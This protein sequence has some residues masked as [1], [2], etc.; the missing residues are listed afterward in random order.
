M[1]AKLSIKAKLLLVIFIVAVVSSALIVKIS[2]DQ[3]AHKQVIQNVD[4]LVDLS[5]V[6]SALVHE[7]QKERGA[8]AGYLGSK[9]KKFAQKLPQQ[10]N[11]TDTR[12]KEFN[13]FISDFDFSQYPG[14]LQNNING[15]KSQ[16]GE[17]SS[18]RSGVTALSIPLGKT[19]KYYTSLNA[20]ILD[21]VPLAGKISD[22]E[23]LAKILVSYSNFLYS[24]ERAGIERAVLSNTFA[25]KEFGPGM[26]EKAVTLIAEQNAYMHSFLSVADDEIKEYYQS[27]MNDASVKEVLQLRAKAFGGDFS[28]DSVYWFDTITKKIN[29]LKNIDDH[30]SQKAQ[31]KVHELIEKANETMLF[32]IASSLTFTLLI[33]L[34]I[35]LVSRSIAN[36]V[37]NANSQIQYITNSRDLSKD[38][39]CYSGGELA[40][41]SFAVNALIEAFRKM[42]SETKNSSGETTQSS[43]ELE[44]TAAHLS[45][46]IAKQQE[47]VNNINLLVKDVS[48][49]LDTTEEMAITTTE[50][51]ETTQLVLDEFVNNLGG[52]VE[53][54]IT[55]SS[56]QEE[57]SHKMAELTNQ[58]AE[59]KNVLSII[60]DI[61]DQ[62]NLLAL[63][64]A[65]EAARAGE[66]GRGFAVVADEVRKLAERTQ[67]SLS[68]IDV[69]TNIITQSIGDVSNEIN[70]IS[71][72][73]LEISESAGLLIEHASDSRNKLD[74]TLTASSEAVK[75]TTY[76]ATKTKELMMHME[77]V[78]DLS[79]DNK[80]AG[81]DVD[82][83]AS[84]LYDKAEHLNTFLDKYT[85]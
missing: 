56:K 38:V 24:K 83:V 41:I 45:A 68:E 75:K 6:L 33:I 32:T 11:L 74:A 84:E 20:K 9:G 39:S 7:T 59:I 37:N 63:N 18:I 34:I 10:R 2:Y 66:H 29:I 42:I 14:E 71:K 61:A 25:L 36:G 16:L 85:I 5:G 49:E 64:A 44:R 47:S 77:N 8:S 58:A 67:K 1:L 76:I 54:I 3:N 73:T 48:A 31:E 50:G 23:S 21:I 57:I 43:A 55:G 53:H 15:I 17:L 72:E 26:F 12:I 60:G 70:T 19:L 40:E 30:L 35:F 62:T 4:M 80:S 13:S 78:V 65:I 46:N 27:K 22:D 79:N 81:D 82:K 52:V 69:T 51:L 28:T